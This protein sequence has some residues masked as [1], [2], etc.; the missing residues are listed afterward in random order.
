MVNN[1]N[2]DQ[3]TKICIFSQIR[4]QCCGISLVFQNETQIG[5]FYYCSKSVTGEYVA[6]NLAN[7]GRNKV[8]QCYNLLYD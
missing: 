6:N 8:F 4:Y 7:F 3:K 5:L 1:T 2:F